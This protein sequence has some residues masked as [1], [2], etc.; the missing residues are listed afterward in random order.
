MI[1]NCGKN[2]GGNK[3]DT[4]G[5]VSGGPTW[6]ILEATHTLTGLCLGSAGSLCLSLGLQ[7]MSYVNICNN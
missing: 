6:R 4:M 1:I 7:I 5:A 3:Q 2:S